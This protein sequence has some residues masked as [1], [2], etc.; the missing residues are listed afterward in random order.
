MIELLKAHKIE[1]SPWSSVNQLSSKYEKYSHEVTRLT[2]EG[3]VSILNLRLKKAHDDAPLIFKGRIMYNPRNGE[4]IKL[5]DWK[6][7]EKA[8]IKYLNIEKNYLQEKM[9]NDSYF[10]GTLLNRIDEMNRRR[11]SLKSFDLEVPE[12]KKYNYNDFDMDKLEVSRQ[13]TGIYLQDVTERTRSKIQK[14]IVEGVKNKQSKYKVFQELWD[15]E[16]DLNRDWD[17][18]IR[19]ETAMNS[20]NGFL[21]SQLRAEPDEEHIF[22]KG[23]SVGDACEYCLRFINEKIIVLL[24]G[25][26]K[27]GEDKVT[28]EGEE[29]SALWPGK[30]NYGR[31][32]VNYW[33]AVVM[34]PYCR[35]SWSR[36]YI[37]LEEAVMKIS[38]RSKKWGEAVEEIKDG[39]LKED[40][41]HFIIE[42]NKLFKQKLK[43]H[44]KKSESYRLGIILEKGR[45]YPEGTIRKWKDSYYKKVSG[46]WKKL[47][48]GIVKKDNWNISNWYK[49]T[50]HKELYN[51]LMQKSRRKEDRS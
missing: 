38:N 23:I 33:V 6:R 49:E 34:H 19:T 35:C 46:K 48:I 18:V 26:P 15:S 22:M 25:P 47:S 32:P 42:V 11:S 43:E 36:W 13:L 1:M 7:L 37:E 14:V 8:I 20:N 21:I 17:R 41:K 5:K 30:S 31:K 51:I 50:K 39:G 44:T 9:T 27:G 28:I 16:V 3:I 24:E 45:K 10:L 29:Y 4:S 40:D 2:L 12:W